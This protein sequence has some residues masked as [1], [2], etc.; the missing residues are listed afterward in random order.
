MTVKNLSYTKINSANTLSPNFDKVNEYIEK[1]NANKHLTLFST[2]KCKELNPDDDLPP[3]KTIKFYETVIVVG[4]VF[5]EGN[6][7]AESFLDEC[8]HKP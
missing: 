8:L 6:K 4:F 1:S 3:K 2:N 5:H 7:F